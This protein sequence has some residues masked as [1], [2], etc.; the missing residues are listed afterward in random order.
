[1]IAVRDGFYNITAYESGAVFVCTAGSVRSWAGIRRGAADA[2]FVRPVRHAAGGVFPL[3][4]DF[5]PV[6]GARRR[7]SF[8]SC[9]RF[10]CL[11]Y[12]A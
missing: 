9:A 3:F 8:I 11:P 5:S 4:V 1:M 10:N 6:C 2:Q 12:A 7:V